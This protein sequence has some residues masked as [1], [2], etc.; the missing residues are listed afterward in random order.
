MGKIVSQT[1]LLLLFFLAQFCYGQ[2]QI[3]NQVDFIKVYSSNRAENSS[4]GEVSTEVSG[5]TD[6]NLK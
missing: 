2:N 6:L 1:S 5:F 3:E 4:T